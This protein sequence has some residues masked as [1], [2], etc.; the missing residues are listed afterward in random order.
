MNIHELA[1]DVFRN[2]GIFSINRFGRDDEAVF[3]LSVDTK[4]YQIYVWVE[5]NK[6]TVSY[7]EDNGFYQ[8]YDVKGANYTMP[9]WTDLRNEYYS[10]S[11][12]K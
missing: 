2:K 9:V 7:Y 8:S 5:Q 12:G 6:M 1:F 11:G 4:G 10:C 3:E